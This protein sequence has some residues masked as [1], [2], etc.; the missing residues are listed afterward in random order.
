MTLR[1]STAPIDKRL[2]LLP[3]AGGALL[4]L[5]GYWPTRTQAG[6]EGAAAMAIALVL[7]LAVAYATLIPA[8][9]RMAK[10]ERRQ[11]FRIALTAGVVRFLTT[12]I[13]VGVAL[14][15]GLAAPAVFLIWVAMSYL[16]LI[17]LETWAL[18]SWSKGIENQG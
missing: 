9:V 11:R 14:W 12:M 2:C 8:M 17:G 18:V 3:M 6:R 4:A 1:G 13:A 7:V 10:A 15:H 16:V 5:L